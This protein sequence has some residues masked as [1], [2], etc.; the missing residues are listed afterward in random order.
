MTDHDLPKFAQWLAMLATLYRIELNEWLNELYW[1]ALKT[2]SLESLA[3]AAHKHIRSPDYGM[4]MPTPAHLIRY[5]EVD[6]KSLAYDAWSKVIVAV[7]RAGV[8]YAVALD[9]PRIHVVINHM[10]GFHRFCLAQES[11][12]AELQTEFIGRYIRLCKKRLPADYVRCFNEAHLDS[13]TLLSNKSPI[14]IGDSEKARLVWLGEVERAPL[15]T[16]E[17]NAD[18]E[19]V[20]FL[21]LQQKEN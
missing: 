7:K 20:L 1:Q 13:H 14:F 12:I 2:Y 8:Y 6:I 15:I 9:D 18:S 16:I 19:L 10:G 5:L 4:F 21:S 17:Y 11:R 3:Q